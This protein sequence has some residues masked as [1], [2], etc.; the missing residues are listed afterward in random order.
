MSDRNP[1]DGPSGALAEARKDTSRIRG[2][3]PA[4]A[5]DACAAHELLRDDDKATLTLMDPAKESDCSND[6]LSRLDPRRR[7]ARR[8]THRPQ[9]PPR[10]SGMPSPRLAPRP[11]RGEVSTAQIVQ[12]V[13]DRGG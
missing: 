1:V 13:I 6:H 9:A 4:V 12:S 11:P 7:M 5:I 2:E 3:T 10:K 8:T